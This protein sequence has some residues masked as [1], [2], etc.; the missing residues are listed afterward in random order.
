MEHFFVIIEA[1]AFTAAMLF[2]GL[3]ATILVAKLD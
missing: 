3:I 1:H 2:M